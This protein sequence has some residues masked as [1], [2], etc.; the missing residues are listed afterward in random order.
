MFRYTVELLRK[1]PSF[2]PDAVGYEALHEFPRGR[3][4]RLIERRLGRP[5]HVAKEMSIKPSDD[6]LASVPANASVFS[7]LARMG[8]E[9][10][11]AVVDSLARVQTNAPAT[12]P[13]RPD[14]QTVTHHFRD[15]PMVRERIS[16]KLRHFDL[17]IEGMNV[18]QIHDGKWQLFFTH[19]GILKTIPL[20]SESAGTRRVVHVFPSLD[21]ALES[22]GLAIMDALDNDLHAD[23]VDEILDWFR[24]DET[25]PLK[26]QLVCSL[27]SLSALNE[28]EKE[29]VFIVEKEQTGIT[30]AYAAKDVEGVRRSANLQKLY[31]GGALGGLPAL[32]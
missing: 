28:L 17:G 16:N 26:A 29:E 11:S 22:G 21:F 31:R 10:F 3:P 23:L 12:A 5:I 20:E 6:R 27:H 8:V 24:R 18:Q 19:A 30:Q 9:D 7:T 25:N 13:I 2:F 14:T 15:N 4:R 32:G 1:K